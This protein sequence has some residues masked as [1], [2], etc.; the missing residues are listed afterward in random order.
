[1]RFNRRMHRYALVLGMFLLISSC[2]KKEPTPEPVPAVV[3]KPAQPRVKQPTVT[4]ADADLELANQLRDPDLLNRLDGPES[5][6]TE[7]VTNVRKPAGQV[8]IKPTTVPTVDMPKTQGPTPEPPV[9]KPEIPGT[10][11]AA[12]N[13]SPT[14]GQ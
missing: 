1:M 2:A 7:T 12:T 11:E 4:D 5:A 6:G 9:Q 8:V 13:K 10:A 14:S 3:N